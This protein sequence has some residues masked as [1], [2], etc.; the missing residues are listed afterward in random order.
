MTV[1]GTVGEAIGGTIGGV[2][3]SSPSRTERAVDLGRALVDAWGS[4]APTMTP[5]GS[6]VAYLSD[7]SGRPEVW[8]QEVDLA[9]PAPAT[10][11]GLTH[12]PVLAVHWSADGAWR[13]CAVATDGGVR[14]QVWVV[15][16]DGTDARRIAGDSRIHAELGPWTRSGHRFVITVPSPEPGGPSTAV[17]ADPVTGHLTPLATGDLIS[18]LDLSVEERLVV[19]RDGRRGEQFCVVVDRVADED[20]PLLPPDHTGGTERALLRP[21]PHGDSS[22]L[23]AYLVTEA[24]LDRHELVALPLGPGGWRGPRRN[25]AARPDAELE[26]LDAD[27]AGTRL[28]LVWNHSGRSEL[29]LLDTGTGER[30]AVPGLPGYVATSPVLSRDGSCVVLAVEGPERPRELWHLDC[31]T[32]VWTRITEVPELPDVPLV[33]PTLE[34]YSG[35]GGLELTGW[36]Y[37]VPGRTGPGPAMLHLHGGPE[38][39]ERPAFSPQ[40]QAMV[41]AGIAVFAPNI[42][43]SS[44]F[45]RHFSHADDVHGRFDAFDDVLASAELLVDRGIAAPDRVAV[46]GRSYGGYLTLAALAFSPGVFAAGVDVCGMSDLQTFYRDTE[47]WIGSAAF[48]KYGHPVSDRKLL[49]QLSPLRKASSIT[50]PL[51]VVHG[52]LDTNVPLGEATQIVAALRKLHR[53]VEYLE[54]EG[55]GHEYRRADSRERL[56][57]TM[58]P[59]L[60]AHLT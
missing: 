33:V 42:R 11:I 7:R 47:P 3:I 23:I 48:T 51:L 19:I 54:L 53:P 20:H 2:A 45:G 44:G 60:V 30:T 4:W 35:K 36:L 34:R 52:E 22:P 58:I 17:L 43:G 18:V 31:G 57:E 24:G 55:E 16:P 41:A 46:T 1:D 59:F 12:N 27:D 25:L 21:A 49:K 39:Q 9:R 38:S 29:E 8:V 6:R 14:Q 13:A 5:D 50:A 40:H 56:L 32:L 28:L 26:A 10:R 15:R 37:D